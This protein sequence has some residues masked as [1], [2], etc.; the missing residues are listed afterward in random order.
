[1]IT[2][3]SQELATRLS[4][5]HKVAKLLVKEQ[6]AYH[7]K[8]VDS[9]W[10]DPKLYSVGD[11]LFA[12]QAV[13]SDANRGQVD[14][15]T[16]PFTDPWRITAKL[17]GALYE[18][19]HWS[20]KIK[21]KKHTSNLSPYPAELIPFQ[22]LDGAD[23]QYGQLYQKFKEHPYKKAV[24]KGSHLRRRSP[25]QPSSYGPAMACCSNGPPWSS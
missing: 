23:N 3:Y 5:L 22:P 13:H 16:Y 7:C 11:I 2:L 25:F 8:F 14:K 15:L 1:M 24:I 6:W 18:L 10:P 20:T 12:Y 4:A 17:H 19:E 21:E 9:Q